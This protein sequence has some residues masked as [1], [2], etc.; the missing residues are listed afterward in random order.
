MQ[1]QA[2]SKSSCHMSLSMEKIYETKYNKN[3]TTIQLKLQY[4]D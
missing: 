3:V 1:S 4:A 2:E